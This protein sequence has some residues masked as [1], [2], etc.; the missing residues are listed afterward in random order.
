MW[1]FLSIGLLVLT[2]WV[3]RSASAFDL[4]I[5]HAV[6][7][8]G[9][10]YNDSITGIMYQNGET[11]TY[12]YS[13]SDRVIGVADIDN[14]VYQSFLYDP[15][16]LTL[17][18]PIRGDGWYGLVL[19]F[20]YDF[21]SNSQNVVLNQVHSL[22]TNFDNA[23][24]CGPFVACDR[25]FYFNVCKGRLNYSGQSSVVKNNQVDLTLKPTTPYA[26]YGFINAVVLAKGKPNQGRQ[27]NGDIS[28]LYFDPTKQPRCWL[29]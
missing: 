9:R 23:V 13:F 6:N 7:Y 25:I 22:L 2:G 11:N 12:Y 29:F 3:T 21:S 26:M 19:Q 4:E 27:V 14:I 28:V 16:A 15:Y 10:S 17:S 18:L 8:G 5:V 1:N 20:A 24:E